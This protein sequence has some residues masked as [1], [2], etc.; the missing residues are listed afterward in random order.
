M[1]LLLAEGEWKVRDEKEL[2]RDVQEELADVEGKVNKLKSQ[3]EHGQRAHVHVHVQWNV[4]CYV[5]C[6]HALAAARLDVRVRVRRVRFAAYTHLTCSVVA[7]MFGNDTTEI[8][9]KAGICFEVRFLALLRACETERARARE[10]ARKTE[11]GARERGR[12][13]ERA[14]GRESEREREHVRVCARQRARTRERAHV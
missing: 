14:S 13:S 9:I 3:C 4:L 7:G 10:S 8:S 1:M 5:H 12:E 2:I 11:T 6:V